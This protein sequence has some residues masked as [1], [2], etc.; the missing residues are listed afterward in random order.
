M[1]TDTTLDTLE[2]ADGMLMIEDIHLG[3]CAMH[4]SIYARSPNDSSAPVETRLKSW[5]RHLFRLPFKQTD[6]LDDSQEQHLSMRFY[7]GFEDHSTPGWQE[8]VFAR[9]KS[10]FF[11]A[12][13]LYELLSVTLCADI[14][15][16][17][18]LA[19]DAS[20]DYTAYG[21][22]YEALRVQRES[23][24]RAWT[25]TRNGRKALLH[26]AT[27][28]VDYNN[29]PALEHT[30]A[31]PIV[32]VAIS[33]AA[34]VV[35]AYCTF[36]MHGCA[37]C[38]GCS[39]PVQSSSATDTAELTMWCAPQFRDTPQAKIESWVENGG[40]RITLANNQTCRC[41][42]KTLLKEFRSCLPKDWNLSNSIAPGVF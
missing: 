6:L 9:P 23:D 22:P 12:S 36:G 18:Q 20:I 32:Y 10:L 3:L 11:G 25:Q 19:R 5:K 8:I 41:D 37:G 1:I 15:T 29:L 28:L 30:L 33:V 4:S 2:P 40:L 7:Y 38:S 39:G 35:W 26:C 31:D 24:T 42:I 17:R 34:L 14:R 16:I 21:S 13:M 27:I